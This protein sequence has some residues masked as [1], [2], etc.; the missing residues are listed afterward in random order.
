MRLSARDM[1]ETVVMWSFSDTPD[2]LG[3]L[4]WKFIMVNC[5]CQTIIV[6]LITFDNF[7]PSLQLL[8][9]YQQQEEVT[10][11]KKATKDRVKMLGEA[12]I[13]QEK[14]GTKNSLSKKDW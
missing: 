5:S 3:L 1:L 13:L 2:W 10:G 7:L 4:Y 11:E 9:F 12:Y 8:H 14:H 6:I